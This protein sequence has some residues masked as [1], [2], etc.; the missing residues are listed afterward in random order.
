[1]ITNYTQIQYVHYKRKMHILFLFCVTICNIKQHA[2]FLSFFCHFCLF[3]LFCIFCVNPRSFHINLLFS[4]F[5]L[6][7]ITVILI[8]QLR[9]KGSSL[10]K[11]TTTIMP[12]I[13]YLQIINLMENTQI[14]R[15][16][17]N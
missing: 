1:M 5:Y 8:C 6:L 4:G 15:T 17:K 13:T 14:N 9:N 16:L 12:N 7:L 11:G 10:S 2:S 3:C